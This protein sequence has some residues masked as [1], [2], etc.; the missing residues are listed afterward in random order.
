MV[1]SRSTSV[2]LVAAMLLA[3][4]CSVPGGEGG[5]SSQTPSTTPDTSPLVTVSDGH[6]V[7]RQGRTV[8][9][10][11]VNIHTLD[12][13]VYREAVGL[14]V[15]FIRVTAPW[16]DYELLPPTGDT[17]H[18]NQP[19]LDQLDELVRFCDAHNISL[20]LDFHQYGWSPYFAPVQ[21]GGRANGIPG[22]F[23]AD[24]RYP[25]TPGGLD[26]A[27]E[28]FYGD[29]RATLLYG[30]FAAMMA[31]R[32]R[33]SPSVLGYEILNEPDTGT[34]PRV[35][36]TTQLV[37]RWEAGILRRLRAIDDE[38]TI[39]FMLRA[40]PAWERCTPTWPDSARSTTW[41][42]TCTTTSPAPAA[43]ATSRTART[44]ARSTSRPFA[45]ASTPAPSPARPPTSMSACRRPAAG[46][47]R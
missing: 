45:A 8:A 28:D 20:L 3:P 22:W 12:P 24:G 40:V 2:F 27:K 43:A 31:E 39:V 9:L 42:W 7:D 23:Y 18:W 46:T 13:A 32:Y 6:F 34:L 47:C 37:V 38:R 17:H 16:S 41:R 36:P 15:N 5:A 21:R 44:S 35:H 14:G 11:G 29:P 4:A 19:R 26:A 33:D 25:V 30:D 10:R 1:G